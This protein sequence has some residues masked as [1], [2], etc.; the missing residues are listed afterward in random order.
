MASLLVVEDDDDQRFVLEDYLTSQ[1]FMV[2]AVGNAERG[3]E[4]FDRFRFD[5][6][7]TD[8]GLPGCS[9]VDLAK[10]VKAE[11]PETRVIVISG[12]ALASD[13][14]LALSVGA[15]AYITKPY[16][17]LELLQALLEIQVRPH[18]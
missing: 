10:Y 13:V 17:P 6:V 5:A 18:D 11:R 14:R 9:G 4:A 15:D 12:R 3:K 1:G 2:Q 16:A 8:V 7:V